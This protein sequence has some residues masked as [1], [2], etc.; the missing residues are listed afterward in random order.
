MFTVIMNSS[1]E[2]YRPIEKNAPL[3]G[4][5]FTLSDPRILFNKDNPVSLHRLIKAFMEN[6]VLAVPAKHRKY[7]FVFKT[8]GRKHEASDMIS[9][10]FSFSVKVK[11]SILDI[12][13]ESR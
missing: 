12:L 3:M 9:V 10:L 11:Y 2:G 6:G 8:T 7:S 1:I 4:G 5:V 13:L